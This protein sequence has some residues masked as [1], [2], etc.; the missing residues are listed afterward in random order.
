MN[1]KDLISFRVGDAEAGRRLDRLVAHHAEISRRNAR[2]WIRLG[3]VRVGGKIVRV[4][5]R[6]ISKG[7]RVDIILHEQEEAPTAEGSPV[8]RVEHIDRQ[9]LVLNKPTGLL[10]EPDRTGSPSVEKIAPALLRDLKEHDKTWLVHRLD[11]QTSGLIMLARTAQAAKALGNAFRHGTVKKDYLAICAGSFERSIE[12]NAPI[13]KEKGRRH[14]VLDSGKPSSTYFKLVAKQPD[15]SLVHAKP[16]TGRTHQIRVHLAHLDHPIAGDG[17]YGGPRYTVGGEPRVIPR[18]ML[19][20]WRLR[21]AHPK[22]NQELVLQ[23]EPPAD[24]ARLAEDAGFL[25]SLQALGRKG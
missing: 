24:F 16:R 8:L 1:S 10:S 20:A 25:E 19:H 4:M 21:F 12:L 13:G 9:V 18:V 7:R 14:A 11:A 22:T 23:V 5:G 2:I 17:L 3:R 6:E 15:F